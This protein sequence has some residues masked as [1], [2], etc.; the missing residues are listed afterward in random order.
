MTENRAL[1][2]G[3]TVLFVDDQPARQASLLRL[4]AA[5]PAVRP[6]TAPGG[7]AALGILK[8]FPVDVLVACQNTPGL[9]GNDLLSV[10]RRQY[11]E[12]EQVL[13]P[14][15]WKQETLKKRVRTALANASR[16]RRMARLQAWAGS[17]ASR[18][19]EAA[20]LLARLQ[21]SD[22]PAVVHSWRVAEATRLFG[23][24]LGLNTADLYA[25]A[26]LHDVGLKSPSQGEKL[27]LRLPG[28]P[29]IASWIR[30]HHERFDGS[31]FP[32]GQRGSSIP[33]GARVLRVADG[34]AE[35]AGTGATEAVCLQ[36]IMQGAGT[37]F[38]PRI[39]KLF[40]MRVLQLAAAGKPPA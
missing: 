5:Y 22:P 25:A 37:E 19:P 30:H 27:V 38:D 35:M 23:E 16:Q 8:R 11:P 2:L 4:F 29:R 1:D 15:P 36:S 40:V 31:G 34:Y 32:D 18:F 14:Q 33:L 24:E 12:V 3:G 7:R 20:E 21:A 26:L 39:A 17:A 28:G 10:C 6:L 13:L 9:S